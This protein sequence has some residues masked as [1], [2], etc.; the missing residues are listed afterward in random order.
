MGNFP[1][2]SCACAGNTF[3]PTQ[4]AAGV[5]VHPR[6]RGEHCSQGKA[7]GYLGGSSPRARGTHQRD[8]SLRVDFW[9]I[10]AC[11]GNTFPRS[12]ALP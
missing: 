4:D 1:G 9:F 8:H 6:V 12:G 2:Q 7:I 11:A 5:P 10:P 3:A